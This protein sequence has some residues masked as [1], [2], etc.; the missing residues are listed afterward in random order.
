MYFLSFLSFGLN[1]VYLDFN[2]GIRQNGEPVCNVDIP[3]W[4]HNNPRLF[5]LI[6]MQVGYK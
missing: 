5:T 4:A 6:H 3:K 2:M 1:I